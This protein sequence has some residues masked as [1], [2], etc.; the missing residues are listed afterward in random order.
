MRCWRRNTDHNANTASSRILPAKGSIPIKVGFLPDGCHYVSS[1]QWGHRRSSL[2][3]LDKFGVVVDDLH[4]VGKS[5][6]VARWRTDCAGFCA[7]V[8]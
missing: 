6:V 3:Q 5:V 2:N 8:L 7:H 4:Q 1:Q